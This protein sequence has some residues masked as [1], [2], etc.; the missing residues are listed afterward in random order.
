[1]EGEEKELEEAR[2]LYPSPGC[3]RTPIW[4]CTSIVSYA[5]AHTHVLVYKCTCAQTCTT[6]TREH[7]HSRMLHEHAV[8]TGTGNFTC[9]CAHNPTLPVSPTVTQP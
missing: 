9:M 2:D 6:C 1:M 5:K 7:K 4:V 8:Y 3:S